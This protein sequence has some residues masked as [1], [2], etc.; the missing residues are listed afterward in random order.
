LLKCVILL[1]VLLENMLVFGFASNRHT[2]PSI[3]Y[4]ACI[5]MI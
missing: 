1:P 3:L 2:Y 4:N 5:I